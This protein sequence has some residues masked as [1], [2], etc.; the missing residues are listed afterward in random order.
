MTETA[1]HP[2]APPATAT[3]SG[4]ASYTAEL[5]RYTTR[6]GDEAAFLEAHAVAIE[7]IRRR[8][9]GLVRGLTVRVAESADHVAWLDVVTWTSRAEAERAAAGCMDVPEFAA[10]A[11]RMTA[12]LA[13]EHGV[14]AREF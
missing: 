2:D 13:M 9:P 12:V 14:I 3:A 6:P 11:A 1:L 5:A 10:C 7:A 4:A 8:F